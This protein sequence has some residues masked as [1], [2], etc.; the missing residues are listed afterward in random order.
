MPRPTA[1]A[2]TED[3]RDSSAKRTL[4]SITDKEDE[5]E[6]LDHG[7]ADKPDASAREAV[8]D[9]QSAPSDHGNE[10][11][12][13]SAP[14]DQPE[15]PW[16]EEVSAIPPRKSRN[17]RR[18]LSEDEDA[19]EESEREHDVPARPQVPPI[20]SPPKATQQ[21]EQPCRFSR[22]LT[23][24]PDLLH[25]I[26]KSKRRWIVAIVPSWTCSRMNL[27]TNQVSH[28]ELC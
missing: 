13:A 28:R 24:P 18:L 5:N 12:G 25:L 21:S 1:S 11:E 22:H 6:Q 17:R 7:L 8:R 4:S 15:E 3:E 2:N 9:E 16:E 27:P 19:G 26:K 20:A 10:R 14:E 23:D